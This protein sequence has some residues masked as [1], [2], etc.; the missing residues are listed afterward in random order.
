MHAGLLLADL[1]AE[2]SQKKSAHPFVL[3]MAKHT[4]AYDRQRMLSTFVFWQIL[5]AW[6][7]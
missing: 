6:R 5:K 1:R 7:R 4:G 2:S 3:V